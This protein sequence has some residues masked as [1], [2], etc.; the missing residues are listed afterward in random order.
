MRNPDYLAQKLIGPEELGRIADH[1][2]AAGLS[3]DYTTGRARIEIAGMANIMLIRT[4]WIEEHLE[5]ALA[6]GAT[7]LVILGA[8][9]DTRAWRFAAELRGKRVFEVDYHSTQEVKKQRV[10][11]TL[12]ARRRT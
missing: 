7:Q 2:I 12:G 9:F 10:Q 4:R 11:A 5:R 6:E 8:G 1:P 3:G